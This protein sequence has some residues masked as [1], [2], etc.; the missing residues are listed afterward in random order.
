MKSQAVKGFWQELFQS[1]VCNQRLDFQIQNPNFNIQNPKIC[2]AVRAFG[3]L[4][5]EI[6]NEVYKKL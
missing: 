4:I 3:I 5:K 6:I 1:F 2:L